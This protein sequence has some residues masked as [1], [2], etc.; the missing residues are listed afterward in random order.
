MPLSLLKGIGMGR[1]LSLTNLALAVSHNDSLSSSSDD[2]AETGTAQGS[3]TPEFKYTS[4]M[5]P[6]V[7][8]ASCS[9]AEKESTATEF[10]LVKSSP[11]A[12]NI[13]ASLVAAGIA[14]EAANEEK[15]LHQQ[16]GPLDP[17]ASTF[18]TD[19]VTT[20]LASAS[21]TFPLSE[22]QAE[23]QLVRGN[24]G[25]AAENDGVKPS[26]KN[27]PK[28]PMTMCSVATEATA[29]SMDDNSNPAAKSS[30]SKKTTKASSSS[31]HQRSRATDILLNLESSSNDA[32]FQEIL[33]N[34]IA[35][36]HFRQFCFQ[37]YSI[38]NL[39]FWMDVELFAKPSPELLQ[40][41]HKDKEKQYDG[42]TDDEKQEKQCGENDEAGQFAVQHARYIY[43]TY[44]DACAPLQVNLSDETRTD[45][46]WPILD[47]ETSAPTSAS[48]SVVSSPTAE[49]PLPRGHLK[50]LL[51]HK[52]TKDVAIGWPLDRR[53]FDG[54]QEHTYQLMKGHTLVRFEDSDLWKAVEKI[55]REQPE[56]YAKAT[57]QGPFNSHYRPLPSV[58]LSTVVRSRSR[59]PSA[60]PQTLYNWNNS[61]SDLDRSRD[62]EEALIMT[63]SQYFGPIPASIRH[64]A[65]V[66][67]GLG[68][69]QDDDGYDD[70]FE[71]FD[72]CGDGRSVPTT[73]NGEDSHNHYSVKSSA[74]S[75]AT[76]SKR[77]R[78]KKHLSNGIGGRKIQ[79]NA[80]D[81]SET[82]DLCGDDLETETIENGR[83]TTRWMVAGYFNDQVRLTAAQRKRLL[84]RNNK[85]TKFFG[86]RVDGT[87]RPVEETGEGG[88]VVSKMGDND[89]IK[90]L[91][92]SNSAPPLGSPLAYALSSST[93]HDMDKKNSKTLKKKSQSRLTR[94][95]KLGSGSGSEVL[96]LLPGTSAHNVHTLGHHGHTGKN[97]LQKFKKTPSELGDDHPEV[98]KTFNSST[99]RNFHPLD[100]TA[101]SLFKSG[102]GHHRSMT[103]TEVHH[104]K[105]ILAHPHPLWSGSLSDQE[106]ISSTVFERRRGLSILSIV[107]NS[108]NLNNGC[109]G[110]TAGVTPTT[111]TMGAFLPLPKGADGAKSS[112]STQQASGR[113]SLDRHAMYT[114]RK[115]AD[116]LSTFF[117]AQLTKQELS[118]QLAMEEEEEDIIV[119][120]STSQHR[121]SGSGNGI[122]SQ[123]TSNESNNSIN[124]S[125]NLQT[126]RVNG[127]TVSSVNQLSHKDRS[128]LWKRNKKLKTILG[129]S[130]PESEVAHALTRPVLLSSFPAKL[131]GVGGQGSS[132]FGGN[133][134][135]RS[136]NSGK[137][138]RKK[139]RSPYGKESSLLT[140]TDDGEEDDDENDEEYEDE[141]DQDIGSD[142]IFGSNIG[143][144]RNAAPSPGSVKGKSR[145]KKRAV[146]AVARSRRPSIA[147]VASS[148]SRNQLQIPRTAKGSFSGQSRPR[149]VH[150]LE[151]FHTIDSIVSALHDGNGD[152]DTDDID[153]IVQYSNS[154]RRRKS[155]V[156]PLGHSQSLCVR[157]PSAT[158]DI[159]RAEALSRFR[160]KKKMDKIQQ[161]LGV[162]VP[163]QD[164][165]MG[166]VGRVRTQEML[167]RQLFSPT[168]SNF[169]FNKQGVVGGS[170]PSTAVSAATTGV[171]SEKPVLFNRHAF[172]RR[173][174]SKSSGEI[175]QA[176]NKS[177]KT[178]DI[179][180]GDA[181]EKSPMDPTALNGVPEEQQRKQMQHK[182]QSTVSKLRRQLASPTVT[183]AD[184]ATPPRT[185]TRG[186]NSI[187][188]I[189][190]LM[191]S[192][193]SSPT[194]TAGPASPKAPSPIDGEKID[195]IGGDENQCNE[196]EDD[197]EPT[198][199]ILPRLRA[200]SGEDQ[201]RFLKRAEKLEKYFGQIPPST[202]LESNLATFPGAS[203]SGRIGVEEGQQYQQEESTT[204][205]STQR[206]L[207]ELAELLAG[208]DN[209]NNA[210]GG[211]NNGDKRL[212]VD[213]AVDTF[214]VA[215][216]AST[217]VPC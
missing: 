96:L 15:T 11:P 12:E 195:G 160:H 172:H 214:A 186:S 20:L 141:D 115:K 68:R 110:H 190:Q 137:T 154:G 181:L 210:V 21:T 205:V 95:I 103:T 107:P 129:E 29:A 23:S 167:D 144:V 22:S 145:I 169:V 202:F 113:S 62:K 134:G 47:Y 30:T 177:A 217:P 211:A 89:G 114:R 139:Q 54:A 14:L 31:T 33:H 92:G 5:P 182:R 163:E 142:G 175:L 135:R 83:R 185:H 75:I 206:S 7:T 45:I 4:S 40:M 158:A 200:M 165:W 71:D 98:Y 197:D 17:R 191:L 16:Q 57:I 116:K 63:M 151:S 70:G 215:K 183:T 19:T 56:E 120:G 174:K 32:R 85:L 99:S 131:R 147:S 212:S 199:K 69:H 84:R 204:P 3:N 126:L 37:E 104:Q 164:L 46:P 108:N 53:M 140:A 192:R 67:L 13:N 161:F 173:N 208:A 189:G 80:S 168:N 171:T 207:F 111:P 216:M 97:L 79:S 155:S 124:S 39:L 146:N 72:T 74:S 8:E 193:S 109:L 196:D 188:G 159:D 48:S 38:E 44:I 2:S 178:Q 157:S 213:A 127:P 209:G 27:E 170:A 64:P 101:S 132:I 166:T 91:G 123:R 88:F 156:R 81:A 150:S 153:G 41:N 119:D 128:I 90:S 187:S 149:S 148:G 112:S 122:A 138:M 58:I 87:L 34:T 194:M 203:Y 117:G 121:R 51:T 162:R 180:D 52:K 198:L 143:L 130:L 102:G 18:T 42:A 86:S 100:G 77:Y 76:E 55:S 60:K 176:E 201:E 78:F 49:K 133:R 106:G 43:L 125:K 61:T 105:R 93:I 28:R 25:L 24:D 50:D 82:M 118:S 179:T 94:G 1:K 35:L 26:T 65:R 9:E 59:H 152:D 73:Q 36:D 6:T 184:R 66:I 136:S 10:S